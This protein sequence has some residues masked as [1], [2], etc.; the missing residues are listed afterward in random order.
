MSVG[1][2]VALNAM[3]TSINEGGKPLMDELI[4]AIPALVDVLH[5]RDV[6][7]RLEALQALGRIGPAAEGAYGDIE[8]V[9]QDQTES[10][11]LRNWAAFAL[12]RINPGNT[13]LVGMLIRALREEKHPSVRRG[14]ADALGYIGPRSR[15]VIPALISAFADSEGSVQRDSRWALQQIGQ[16]AVPDLVLALDNENRSIRYSAV[17]TLGDIG[18]KDRSAVSKLKKLQ[19]DDDPG[20]A[21]EARDALR[22]I[23]TR[24][25]R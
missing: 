4:K 3:T 18:S 1:A 8:K 24:R 13:Q 22:K 5:D 11:L 21:Q 19:G 9:F 17:V 14:A 16:D 7:A 12:S 10:P 23:S 20:I 25:R 15:K 6:N 2:L